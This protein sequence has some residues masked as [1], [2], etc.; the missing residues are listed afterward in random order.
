MIR[1]V[2][3][4]LPLLLATPSKAQAYTDPG[5]GAFVFQAAYA[6]FL[7]GTYYFRKFLDRLWRKRSSQESST[8]AIPNEGRK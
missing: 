8:G 3:L 1:L 5:T 7:G 6:A 2:L 4:C